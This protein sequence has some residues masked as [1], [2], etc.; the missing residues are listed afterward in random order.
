MIPLCILHTF[1]I[2]RSCIQ[3]LP[4]NSAASFYDAQRYLNNSTVQ[5]V[6]QAAVTCLQKLQWH[7]TPPRAQRLRDQNNW[8][9]WVGQL[10][11]TDLRDDPWS[12]RYKILMLRAVHSSLLA[13]TF[14]GSRVF[15][16]TNEGIWTV[17]AL[18]QVALSVS[19]L[20]F[21]AT[22]R[23]PLWV[24]L[25]AMEPELQRAFLEQNPHSPFW[26]NYLQCIFYSHC[27]P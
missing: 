25:R 27:T 2:D 15:V 22:R 20:F 8:V 7:T 14:G 21:F 1:I 6:R 24:L 3:G 10:V 12:F 16:R 5:Q 17:L 19:E 26:K 9:N 13:W 18:L 11:L 23:R 4:P